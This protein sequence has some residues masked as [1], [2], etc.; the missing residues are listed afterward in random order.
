MYKFL[1]FLTYIHLLTYILLFTESQVPMREFDR[2]DQDLKFDKL[3]HH[4]FTFDDGHIILG[5]RKIYSLLKR[6]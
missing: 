1:L 6:C 5:R 3:I 4:I 2:L